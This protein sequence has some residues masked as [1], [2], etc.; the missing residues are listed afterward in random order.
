MP[1]EDRVMSEASP[2]ELL[3]SGNSP[4]EPRSTLVAKVGSLT[5]IGAAE[6]SI[7]VELLSTWRVTGTFT[8]TTE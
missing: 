2:E 7:E 1:G 3:S 5:A 4:N 8:A 6:T